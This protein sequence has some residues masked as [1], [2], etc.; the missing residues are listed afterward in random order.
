M[1]KREVKLQLKQGD[2]LRRAA[3]KNLQSESSDNGGQDEET[4]QR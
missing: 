2:R 3:L 1:K 4:K